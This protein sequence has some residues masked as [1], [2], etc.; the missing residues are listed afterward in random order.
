MA[1]ILAIR[2]SAL[3]DVAMTVPVLYSFAQAYPQHQIVVLSRPFMKSLF[4]NAPSNLSFRG[5]DVKKDYAGIRGLIR[6]FGELKAERFDAV[7]DL[8]DV[9]RSKFLRFCFRMSGIPVASIDKNRKAR[10]RLV[11]LTHKTLCRQETSF[12]RYTLVLKKLGYSFPLRFNSIYSSGKGDIS[13]LEP[14]IGS[15]QENC[16]WIGIAPFAAHQGK[17]YP[18]PLMEQ[19][20]RSLS[21]KENRQLFLFGGGPKETARLKQWADQFP[22]V[23]S[24]A[25]AC[26]MNE[27]L[28]LMSHL[29][30]MVSMDSGNMHLASLVNV[31]VVSIWG[32]T[33]PFAGFMGWNQHSDNAIQTELPCRPCSIFGNKPCYRKDYACLNGILPEMIIQKVEKLLNS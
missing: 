17:I 32:A 10:K 1:K 21:G 29:D 26:N 30:V 4:A 25:G 11:S 24:I 33:H 15:K 8:H 16:K 14:L 5:T 6:L 18:L 22:H 19:V 3:G 13:Q 23:V 31:P 27:E 28:A 7:A 20:I 9:L 2:F 12:E